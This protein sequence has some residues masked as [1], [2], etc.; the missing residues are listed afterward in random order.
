MRASDIVGRLGGEEFVALLPGTAS[1]A[2]IAAERVRKAFEAAGV[3]IG[4]CELNATVSIGA[5]CGQPGT[6]IVALLAAADA[7]LYRAKA[8][9]RNRVEIGGEELPVLIKTTP[10][11]AA[12]E[13]AAP[14]V[15]SVWPAAA[16]AVAAA[17]ALAP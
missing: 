2:R 13:G 8:K 17:P 3:T 14:K 16:E 7:A 1:D 5:A 11:S 4:E 12:F 10:P 15:A 9:G 6:D